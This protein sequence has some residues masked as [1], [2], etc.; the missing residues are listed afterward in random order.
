MCPGSLDLSL[1]LP[2]DGQGGGGCSQGWDCPS[3]LL[4]K[5]ES[6]A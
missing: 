3:A 1:A 5:A 6:T 2:A 4:L